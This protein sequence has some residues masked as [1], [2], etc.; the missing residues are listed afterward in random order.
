MMGPGAKRQPDT[1]GSKEQIQQRTAPGIKR[2]LVIASAVAYVVC[3]GDFGFEQHF[4]QASSDLCGSCCQV[5]HRML[6][7]CHLGA[8]LFMWSGIPV[9][10]QTTSLHRPTLPHGT[11]QQVA[12]DASSSTAFLPVTLQLVVVLPE[13]AHPVDH[14]LSGVL[15]HALHGLVILD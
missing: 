3:L 14:W 15:A 7:F 11:M 1:G 5:P 12:V 13:G 6:M 10:W 2:L 4:K 9:W 8:V